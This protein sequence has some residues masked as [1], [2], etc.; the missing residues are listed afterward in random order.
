MDLI[1]LKIFMHV[2]EPGGKIIR[3]KLNF[4][5]PLDPPHPP[6]SFHFSNGPSVKQVKQVRLIVLTFI[7]FLQDHAWSAGIYVKFGA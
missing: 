4:L 1:V 6:F 5:Y 7:L 2:E 3:K